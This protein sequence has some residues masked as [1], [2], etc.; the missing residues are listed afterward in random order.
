M[1]V[2]VINDWSLCLDNLHVVCFVFDSEK[3]N[4]DIVSNAIFKLTLYQ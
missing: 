2:S 4:I 3:K 1:L